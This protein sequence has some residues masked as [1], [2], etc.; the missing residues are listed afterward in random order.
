MCGIAG[1]VFQK[2][3]G[4]LPSVP[5]IFN[6]L[7][8]RGPDGQGYLTYYPGTVRSGRD[9]KDIPDEHSE[10]LLVHR[11]LSILDLSEAGAQPMGTPDGRYYITFNGEIYNHVELRSEL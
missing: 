1:L 10:V 3:D 8:H 2:S 9:W 4:P 11:R 6:R 7:Q 5:T